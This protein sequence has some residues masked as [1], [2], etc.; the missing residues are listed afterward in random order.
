MA[1]DK[2]LNK[3][4]EKREDAD[5]IVLCEYVKKEILGYDDSMKFPNA[6][7]LRLKGLKYGQHIANNNSDQ[8]AMYDDYTLLCTFKLCRSRIVD[9]LTVNES[10]IKDEKHKINL[11]MKI[12][13]PE[14]NDVA[15]RLKQA[16]QS[17]RK[18]ERASF[19]TQTN[20]S[21]EYKK[22]TKDKNN[23]KLNDLF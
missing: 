22:K 16:K 10:K 12:V 7:A 1:V 23:K 13:E 8:K 9:Y 14:V 11:I 19:D 3:S 20:E 5:W 2:T 17:Q 18:I 21:A 15:I 4:G 6:L